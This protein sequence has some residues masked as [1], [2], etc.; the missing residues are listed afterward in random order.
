MVEKFQIYI[1]YNIFR[2][3]N[4]VFNEKSFIGHCKSGDATCLHILDA[5]F[6][7][8]NKI[9]LCANNF[10]KIRRKLDISSVL[11]M[12]ENNRSDL[13]QFI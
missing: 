2:F 13:N 12:L 8:T 5:F 3:N 9:R 1:E 4:V 11:H 10:E 7:T 6:K